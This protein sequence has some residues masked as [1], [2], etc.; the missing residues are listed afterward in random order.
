MMRTKIFMERKS[1]G[2]SIWWAHCVC[3]FGMGF[4]GF[5]LTWLEDAII[6]WK[7]DMM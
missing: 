5:T 4:V 1:N 3:G 2:A 6:S 7:F